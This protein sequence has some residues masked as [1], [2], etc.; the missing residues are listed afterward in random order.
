MGDYFL[1]TCWRL[2]FFWYTMFFSCLA[3]FSLEVET[4]INAMFWQLVMRYCVL[5]ATMWIFVYSITV[6]SIAVGAH[7]KQWNHIH[8]IPKYWM[9]FLVNTQYIE[10]V[11]N[12]DTFIKTAVMGGSLVLFFIFVIISVVFKDRSW[13]S[14]IGFIGIIFLCY[15]FANVFISCKPYALVALWTDTI[16]PADRKELKASFA[17]VQN[18]VN[19]NENMEEDNMQQQ[20]EYLLSEYEKD[21]YKYKD[22][23][24]DNCNGN[25]FIYV[26]EKI[27]AFFFNYGQY[28]RCVYKPF[29]TDNNFGESNILYGF[30][31]IPLVFTCRVKK[32]LSQNRKFQTIIQY[33]VDSCGNICILAIIGIFIAI[34]FSLAQQMSGNNTAYDQLVLYEKNQTKYYGICSDSWGDPYSGK[35]YDLSVLDMT[36]LVQIVYE[37]DNYDLCQMI[38]IYFNGEFEVFK[39]HRTEPVFIHIR[40]KSAAI[41]IITIRGTDNLLEVVQDISLWVEVALFEGLQW[42]VPFLGGLPLTFVRKI[43]YYASSVE[44]IINSDVRQEFDDPVTKYAVKYLTMLENNCNDSSRADMTSLYFVGHSLGGGIAQIVAAN[45]YENYDFKSNIQSYGVCSPGVLKSSAK[46]GFG[47]DALDKTSSSLLPRR[48]I[49][50]KVDAHGGSIQYTECD[51]SSFVTCHATNNVL[52][53]LYHGCPADLVD[54][55]LLNNTLNGSGMSKKDLFNQFCDLSE[56]GEQK[57][58][59]GG[60]MGLEEITDDLLDS[61]NTCDK[62]IASEICGE[63]TYAC[64]GVSDSNNICS[65][66][67]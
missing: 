34:L 46:F 49:V 23:T 64:N 40:H 15:Y 66:T 20:M 16:P 54:D 8:N 57:P 48:D 65:F 28:W 59:F 13:S 60:I 47:V 58:Q 21:K 33:F 52:C 12:F 55:N 7:Y 61:I 11:S 42:I 19:I 67:K 22:V 26:K 53:E 37:S 63:W 6:K 25:W 38:D 2:G 51:A 35:Q 31:W 30:Q 5:G 1:A 36:F 56:T 27:R 39:V 10:N 17:D 9:P 18:K 45:L 3:A 41:D 32:H 62:R 44:G 24:I 14:F 29:D 43:I 50:S 4:A